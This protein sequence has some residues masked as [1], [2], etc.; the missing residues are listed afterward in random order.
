MPLFLRFPSFIPLVLVLLG[1][2]GWATAA[3]QDVRK[4]RVEDGR[5]F[6]ALVIES[7][8]DWML[9]ETPQGRLR[10][11]F[12]AL[13][14]VLAVDRVAYDSQSSLRVGLAPT[15]VSDEADRVLGRQLD[16]RLPEV[17][18]LLPGIELISAKSWAQS[19]ADRGMELPACGGVASCLRPLATE[20]KVDRF[21]VPMLEAETAEKPDERRLRLDS[22]VASSGATM[23]PSF[24][25][26]PLDSGTPSP[27]HSAKSLLAAT[28]QSLGFEPNV[29]LDDRVAAAFPNLP[30]RKLTPGQP[31]VTPSE[32][33]NPK[34]RVPLSSTK[35]VELIPVR[36][37]SAVKLSRAE[38]IALGFVPVPGLAAALKRDP[39]GFALAMAGTLALSS[40][41][42][43]SV[44]RHARS[45]EAFWGPTVAAP[46][47][48]CVGMNQLSLI[49]EPA[50]R[51]RAQAERLSSPRRPPM[52]AL[53]LAIVPQ[54]DA[55]A[56]GAAQA[57]GAKTSEAPKYQDLLYE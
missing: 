42:I 39:R 5:T 29:D 16:R 25:E 49:F 22:V 52:P 43:Y 12:A 36:D 15:R 11:P 54:I 31:L 3:D 32:S 20:S 19:L 50:P 10:I 23:R 35:T 55:T 44:G 13:T 37:R 27:R 38:E 26:L 14:D 1:A 21:L 2:P 48:I 9:I 7:D 6:T 4:L 53:G 18:S 57:S 33:T 47:A 41:V 8:G 28:F 24:L 45:A 17:L 30:T 51:G 46:Y 56:S 34:G 40:A